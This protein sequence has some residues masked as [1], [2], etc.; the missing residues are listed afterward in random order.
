[1]CALLRLFGGLRV[2]EVKELVQDYLA[3]PKRIAFLERYL[4]SIS[5]MFYAH[6]S[7]VGGMQVDRD[8]RG[9]ERSYTPEQAT[10]IITIQEERVNVKI[11]RLFERWRL[12][13]ECLAGDELE[14]L[15][16]AV[17]DEYVTPLERRVFGDICEIEQYMAFK[18][19]GVAF[20][21][22]GALDEINALKSEF[23]QLLNG[24]L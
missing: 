18:Y 14:A 19:H 21:E 8:T 3:I 12:F 13:I 24:G 1:M 17:C 7:I 4:A 5:P 15:K 10:L 2:D 22:Y 23:E 6:H 9:Y 16:R 11:K 20:E